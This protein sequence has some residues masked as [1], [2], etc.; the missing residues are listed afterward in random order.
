V[1]QLAA[2]IA[3]PASV[4]LFVALWWFLENAI[5]AAAIIV[6][7]IFLWLA[8]DHWRHERRKLKRLVDSIRDTPRHE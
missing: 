8:F 7:P 1:R 2:G 4:V 5:L 3:W 6:G